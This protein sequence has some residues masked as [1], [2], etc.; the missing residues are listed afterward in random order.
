MSGISSGT[1]F[2]VYTAGSSQGQG[3]KENGNRILRSVKRMI[4]EIAPHYLNNSFA[5][6]N[7]DSESAVFT[8]DNGKVLVYDD[9]CRIHLPVLSQF[10]DGTDKSISEL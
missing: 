4:Q 5:K 3:N 7:A 1:A 2:S 8:F 6:V 10:T 9:G